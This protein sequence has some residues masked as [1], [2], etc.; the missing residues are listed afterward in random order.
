MELKISSP[1]PDGL[2]PADCVT[3]PEEREISDDEDDDRNHKHRRRDT[4]SQSLERD[5]LEQVLRRPYRKRNK[6]FE[7]GHLFRESDS[8]SQYNVDRDFSLKY[9]KRR[10]GAN[11]SRVSSGLNLRL[12][13]NQPFVGDLGSVRGRG[14]DTSSWQQHDSRFTSVDI[15]SQMAQPG[16][17]AS[18]M[19][20]GRGIP[21]A[22]NAHSGS[23]SGFGLIPRIPSGGIDAIHPLG[24]QGSVRTPINPSLSL[25]IP[26]QRCRDFE[27]RGFC[28]RGDMCPMEHGVNRIVVEDVQ[29]LSQFN[30]PVSLPNTHLLG[31]PAGTGLMQTV[32]ASSSTLINSKGP[33]SRVNKLGVDDDKFSLGGAFSGPVDGSGADVY[34][35]DQPLWHSD[36][37]ETSTALL[38]LQPPIIDEC[39]SSMDAEPSD[40]LVR[41][42]GAAA[43]LNS[44]SSSVWGRIRTSKNG[45]EVND[46]S[47]SR[48]NFSEHPENRVKE[49][50]MASTSVKGT[51]LIG[52]RFNAEEFGPKAVDSSFKQQNDAGRSARKLSQKA[53]RTLFVN[54]IPLK[55]NK[56]EALLVH[57]R[58]FGEVIDIY[59]PSNTERAFVQFSRREEAEAALKAPDAVMGNRFIKMWWANRDSIPDDGMSTGN[60]APIMPCDVQAALVPHPTTAKGKDILEVPTPKVSTAYASDSPASASNDSKP[61]IVSGAK[62]PPL[63]Q[64]KLQNLELLEEIRRKQELLEKKR[65]EF[66]QQLDKLEKHA[67]GIKGE[68]PAE[69]AAKRLKVGGTVT[70]KTGIP[71]SADPVTAGAISPAEASADKPQIV[72]NSVSYPTATNSASSLV[73]ESPILELPMEFALLGTHP[74]MNEDKLDYL[75]ATFRVNPPLPTGLEDVDALRDHF[76][77]YGELSNVE[78]ED[79]GAQDGVDT[80]NDPETARVCS[81]RIS[82]TTQG[83]AERAFVNGTSWH[84]NNLQFTWLTTSGSNR[85]DKSPLPKGLLGAE[86]QL[87][88]DIP[89]ENSSGATENSSSA[90]KEKSDSSCGRENSPPAHRGPSGAD[91]AESADNSF[92][93]LEEHTSG[94]R[95]SE[96]LVVEESFVEHLEVS[97]SFESSPTPV[98]EERQLQG[99]VC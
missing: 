80:A 90:E 43:G 72:D 3:D 77:L 94:K 13:V 69:Q 48:L 47:G 10:P 59:I 8:Q 14:R 7:N 79:A 4:Q 61:V 64:K 38:A 34:D 12:K 21:N 17:V 26:S 93:P 42:N 29:S 87:A 78:L 54:C 37:P 27:E 11:Y 60:N 1:K 74:S 36:H 45:L 97:K 30:L 51:S 46:K 2:S 62:A 58:K 6:P 15:A 91:E 89:H 98:S 41:S 33:H 99:E 81:A 67:T 96:A 28:L 25:G 75:T 76:S 19:L 50:Q 68:I 82:F 31:P 66:R 32:T 63:L 73:L 16:S 39:E 84:G 24:L 83:A 95:D 71:K 57:F 88:R 35:P 23:W 40:R 86:L 55:D 65:N 49:S 18:A 53:Q 92:I 85:R 56:K 22:S 20:A 70:M 5:Q 44:T 52:K 9:D